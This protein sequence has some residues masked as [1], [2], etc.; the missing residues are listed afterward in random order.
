[1]ML[2]KVIFVRRGWWP[3]LKP[4]NPP[5]TTTGLT[6]VVCEEGRG[7]LTVVFAS[8]A[9]DDLA[10]VSVSIPGFVCGG[11]ASNPSA[12]MV[13]FSFGAGLLVVGR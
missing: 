6:L 4:G 12:T 9:C 8:P 3:G 1:M 10:V 11:T 7:V 2:L 13:S 5:V